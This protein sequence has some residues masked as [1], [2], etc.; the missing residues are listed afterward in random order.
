MQQKDIIN[1]FNEKTASQIQ[2]NLQKNNKQGAELISCSE[3]T[4]KS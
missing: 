3:N 2:N 4:K 1:P